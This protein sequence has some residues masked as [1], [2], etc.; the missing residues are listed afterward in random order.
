MKFG[1]IVGNPPYQEIISKTH[2]NKSLGKQLFPQFIQLSSKLAENYVS[3][4][5]PSKWFTGEGQ[6]G[7]FTPLRKWAEENNHFSKIVNI[8]NGK[9]V[10]PETELGAVNYFLYNKNYNGNTEFSNVVGNSVSIDERPL[11]ENNVDI[12]L[13]MNEMVSILNKVVK[14]EGF[15]SFTTITCGRNA[16][17]VVGKESE[18]NK[19]TQDEYFKNAVSLRCAHE[20]I[21]YIKKNYITKNIDLVDKWK[22]FT[23]KGNGGAGVLGGEKPVAI[24]GKSYIGTPNS[25]CTD[26]LIP[27]GNF[28][29]EIEAINLQKYMSTKFLRF[30][31][32]ILK[33]SQNIYQNVYQFVPIQNFNQDSDINWE[34][35]IAEI[36]AQLYD[37]YN[38][39][40]EERKIIEKM[41]KPME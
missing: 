8:F 38:L 15:V 35:S 31:V 39:T 14:Q 3:L 19:I 9:A 21:K 27:I 1:A 37:K 5:T 41:I 18:V 28:N 40:E 23:S 11:F 6:D 32:G 33:V 34:C 24:L 17:G 12:I 22:I 13:S 7:S 20:Q 4:I 29:T 36:D 16:F 26:S 25:A 30:M 10:F 2:G